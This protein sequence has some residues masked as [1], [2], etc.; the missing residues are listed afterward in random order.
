MKILVAEDDVDQLSLRCLLLNAGGFETLPAS[1]GSSAIELAT[2][3]K[4]QCAVVDLRLPTDEVGW[5]LISALK[6]LDPKIHVVVLTGVRAEGLHRR[7][8]ATL[9]DEIIVKGSSSVHLI[10]TLQSIAD[11]GNAGVKRLSGG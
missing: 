2:A 4:P 11:L 10:Q 1:D 8:E 9:V 3:E 7:P 6:R 5:R